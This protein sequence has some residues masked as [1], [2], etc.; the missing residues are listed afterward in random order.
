MKR[1][2]N[3][4]KINNFKILRVKEIVFRM[5]LSGKV[6]IDHEESE[7][8]DSEILGSIHRAQGLKNPIKDQNF[9]FIISRFQN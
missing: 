1:F 4:K 7:N 9:K 6:K 3:N 8:R 5:H 2:K